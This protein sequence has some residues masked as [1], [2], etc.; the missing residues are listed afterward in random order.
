MSPA[1]FRSEPLGLHVQQDGDGPDVLLIAGL[2]DDSSVWDPQVAALADRF[3]LT[4]YDSRGT[5]GAPNA[6]HPCT[7]SSLV[8]DAVAVL[9]AAKIARAHV[10]GVAAGGVIA[11]RLAIDHP[12][13]VHGIVLGATWA[14]PDRA[15]RALYASWRWAAERASSIA[16]VL[17]LVY[18]ATAGPAAWNSGEIDRRIAAAEIREV[19]AGERSWDRTRDAFVSAASAAVEEDGTPGLA[20]VRAPAL[21]LAGAQDPVVGRHHAA[22]L[23]SLL[24]DITVEILAGAGHRPA[25]EQ[26]ERFN[27]QLARF[28]ARTARPEPAPA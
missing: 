15:L 11:Q 28:F 27:E 3:R 16:P 25:E 18:G 21:I 17:E 19:R 2:A 20:G 9:D 7:P 4:R 12:E 23:A 8:A 24:P 6:P 14:R 13:R 1:A 5:P 10:V 26:P 22:Q